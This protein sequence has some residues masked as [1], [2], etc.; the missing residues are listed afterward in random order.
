M[1]RR[2]PH[3]WGILPD[4][5][6]PSLFTVLGA[7]FF[8]LVRLP[9]EIIEQAHFEQMQEVGQLAQIHYQHHRRCRLSGYDYRQSLDAVYRFE[10]DGEYVCRVDGDPMDSKT[11]VKIGKQTLTTPCNLMTGG[12]PE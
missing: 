2:G 7:E 8:L 5:Y 11:Y 12:S 4:N 9:E 10:V 6:H 1:E 3:L